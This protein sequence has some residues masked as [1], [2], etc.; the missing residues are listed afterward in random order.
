MNQLLSTG[1][2]SV[3]VDLAVVIASNVAGRR[4]ARRFSAG[5]A[6]HSGHI[7]S[8]SMESAV[9]DAIARFNPIQSHFKRIWTAHILPNF[10]GCRLHRA[11]VC[12]LPVG[13][14]C[15]SPSWFCQRGGL[16]RCASAAG[17]GFFSDSFINAPPAARVT[18]FSWVTAVFAILTDTVFVVVGLAVLRSCA[19]SQ[20]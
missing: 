15:C 18:W 11:G 4:M 20:V 10:F 2:C 12:W 16:H 17:V 13:A 14:A 1:C 3:S 19:T 5:L 6:E 8:P 7:G 9:V